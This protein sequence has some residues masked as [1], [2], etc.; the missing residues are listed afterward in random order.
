MVLRNKMITAITAIVVGVLFIV[1]KGEV[2]SFALTILGVAAIVMGILDMTRGAEPGGAAII[3]IGIAIVAFG[4]LFVSV[5]LYVIAALMI[6][7]CLGN[8]VLS[9]KTDG[10]SLSAIQAIRAYAKPI[11][12]LVAGICLF[13]NQG[14]TVDWVFV[15][16]GVIFVLEGVM[17]LSECRRGGNM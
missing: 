4:W 6:V 15:L 10:F 8:L 13:F 7:Y 16:T 12:G 3:I 1:L 2:V 17:M 14:G 5:T 11:I 9:L